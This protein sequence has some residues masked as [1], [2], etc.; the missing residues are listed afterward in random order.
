MKTP[1]ATAQCAAAKACSHNSS[2][3]LP[4][5]PPPGEMPRSTQNFLPPSGVL[6]KMRHSGEIDSL[7]YLVGGRG[8]SEI[9]LFA[10]NPSE[11]D[12]A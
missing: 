11:G 1:W 8:F 5:F 12:A 4:K 2:C 9:R 7:P 6:R 10:Q 3:R